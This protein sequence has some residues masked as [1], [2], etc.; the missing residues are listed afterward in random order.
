MKH[1]RVIIACLLASTA[2][3]AQ[4]PTAFD[5]KVDEFRYS[6]YRELDNVPDSCLLG[7]DYLR[8]T[9]I[10]MK[11][12]QFLDDNAE[13]IRGYKESVLRAYEN[14]PIPDLDGYTS[15]GEEF[16]MD[17][18]EKFRLMSDEDFADYLAMILPK[19]YWNLITINPVT[20]INI[21]IDMI[22]NLLGGSIML[23][24]EVM[25]GTIGTPRISA[26][27]SSDGVLHIYVDKYKYIYSFEYRSE[28]DMLLLESMY[29][30]N[31]DNEELEIND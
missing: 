17:M 11:C 25:R 28:C 4:Q 15:Q 12:K 18:N 7:S 31:N 3:L 22:N 29:I 5:I 8:M 19:S 1:I 6:L 23:A 14:N 21:Y 2:C 9:Q 10:E 24:A 13:E 20:R 30:R 16:V 27:R 26:I